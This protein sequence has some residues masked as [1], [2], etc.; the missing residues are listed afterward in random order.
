MGRSVARTSSAA[1]F[2]FGA[3]VDEIILASHLDQIPIIGADPYLNKLLVKYCEEAL[4]GE[5]AKTGS[6]RSSVENAVVPLWPH[7]QAE[8]GEIARRLGVSVSKIYVAKHRISG[9]IKKEIKL[10][11]NQSA[12]I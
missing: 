11:E 8:V 9:L 1:V 3:P 5:P 7:G 2:E 10:I 6:F 12:A 4:A